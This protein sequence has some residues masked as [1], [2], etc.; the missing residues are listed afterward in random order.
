MTPN[1]SDFCSSW[2]ICDWSLRELSTLTRIGKVA[3][4]CCSRSVRTIGS[5]LRR[6]GI[7]RALPT[8]LEE[9]VALHL[10]CEQLCMNFVKKS[11]I[12]VRVRLLNFNG[13][14]SKRLQ[15]YLVSEELEFL[16]EL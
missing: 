7:S 10:R 11:P 15:H 8:V 4:G 1:L 9:S 5:N 6:T 2:Q 16:L 13:T 3:A 14:S 12:Y